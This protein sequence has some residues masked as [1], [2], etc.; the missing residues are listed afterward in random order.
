MASELFLLARSGGKPLHQMPDKLPDLE[1]AGIALANECSLATRNISD[2]RG[3][4]ID[5]IDPWSG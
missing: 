2:F 4:G 3:L 1:I 5:L